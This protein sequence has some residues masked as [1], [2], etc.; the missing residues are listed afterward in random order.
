MMKGKGRIYFTDVQVTKSVIP[1]L[2]GFQ[3]K[4]AFVFYQRTAVII[5]VIVCYVLLWIKGI[6]SPSAVGWRLL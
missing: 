2:R 3:Q 6:I 1:Q 4:I 5:N